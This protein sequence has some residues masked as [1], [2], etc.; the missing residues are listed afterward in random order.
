MQSS[1][2]ERLLFQ[3]LRIVNDFPVRD[4]FIKLLLS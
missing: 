2:E 4:D 3:Q 1:L